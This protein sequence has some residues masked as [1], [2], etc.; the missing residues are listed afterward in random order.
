MCDYTVAGKR[1][2]CS[3]AGDSGSPPGWDPRTWA[4]ISFHLVPEF[5]HFFSIQA[6]DQFKCT[7]QLRNLFIQYPGQPAAYALYVSCEQLVLALTLS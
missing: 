7:L 1:R 5:T 4:C 6:K 2:V 3:V